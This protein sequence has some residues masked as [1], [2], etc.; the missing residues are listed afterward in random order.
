LRDPDAHRTARLRDRPPDPRK[1]EELTTPVFPRYGA[2]RI[3]VIL[4]LGFF[5]TTNPRVRIHRRHGSFF[6]S[7]SG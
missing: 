3:V 7:A 2:T 5:A 6:T 1:H 4:G